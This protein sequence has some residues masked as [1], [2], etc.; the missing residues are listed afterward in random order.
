[1][2]K[3]DLQSFRR[4]GRF[5]APDNAGAVKNLTIVRGGD[6]PYRI[7]NSGDAGSSFTVQLQNIVVNPKC[8]VDVTVIGDVVIQQAAGASA[9]EGIYDA[10]DSQAASRSG[11]FKGS[12]NTE[13]VI[14]QGRNGEPYRV[15]NSGEKDLEVKVGSTSVGVIRPR[16]SLDLAGVL[17]NISVTSTGRLQGMYEYL[18]RPAETR[19][20]R[21]RIKKDIANH[22]DPSQPYTIINLSSGSAWYRIFNSGKNLFKIVEGATETDLLP[23]QSFDFKVGPTNRVI[24]VK[25]TSE[26]LPIQG[27]YDF[28]R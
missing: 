16:H 19:S 12:A 22:I 27:I 2:A 18:A 7:F 15:L 20:G 9:V 3:P 23:E 5:S 6:T 17:G 21:F 25:S 1:M 11:R 26:N 14:L 10:I 24:Q 13:V 8:S 28:I 4:S